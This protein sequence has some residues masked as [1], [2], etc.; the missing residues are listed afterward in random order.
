[1][2][3]LLLDGLLSQDELSIRDAVRRFVHEEVLPGVGDWFERGEFPA[4]VRTGAAEL[5]LLGMHLEGYGCLGANATSYG[6]ACLELEAGDSGLRSFVSVQGSLSM[7]PI[8]RYGSDEQKGEWLPQM[9]AG[10]AI[11]CF[12]LT[13]ADSGSDP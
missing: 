3:P 1:M 9:A 2:D 10:E 13:E 8:H 11:G 4:E 6:L 12:G 7:F 5:G